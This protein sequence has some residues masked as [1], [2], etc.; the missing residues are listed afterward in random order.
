MAYFHKE[1]DSYLQGQ[2][3]FPNGQ[4]SFQKEEF[5]SGQEEFSSRQREV[6][7]RR[8]RRD[9]LRGEYGALARLGFPVALTQ[10]GIIALAFADTIMVGHY[11]VAQLAAAAFVNSVFLIPMVMLMGL[12]GG[13]T[14]LVGA[15]YGAGDTRGVGEVARGGV[16]VDIIVGAILTLLMTGLYFL[17]DR[18]GQEESLL[19]EIKDYYLILLFSLLP[20]TIFNAFQQVSNGITDTATPMWM[21]L[22][23]VVLNIIGN[24]MLIYGNWGC[25]ELGL[26][27]AGI[28]TVVSRCAGAVGM[29]TVFFLRRRYRPYAVGFRNASPGAPLLRKVWLTSYPVMIQSGV[30]C[31]LWSF[32]AVV[33]GW[34]GAV[35]LAAYQ[36][37]NTIGQL[38]FMIFMSIGVAVS[39]RVANNIGAGNYPGASLSARAGLHLNWLLATG[40]SILFLG[41]GRILIGFFTPDM[42]VISSALLLLPPLALYQ[43][44]DAT[45]L[46][47]CNAIRGTSEVKPLLWISLAS[48]ILVGIPALLLFACQ[49][50]WGNLGVYY[51]FCVALLTAALLA[52]RVFARI[53]ARF[54]LN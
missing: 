50:G 34:F 33:C 54:I 27:G 45:Q 49:F 44:L 28:A 35:S 11:G 14:P 8:G 31:S 1:K 19:P 48:Y 21:I 15:L 30:E 24:Y 41:A 25:P 32:G 13:I 6:S 53:R 43:Y 29:V 22:G 39:V 4:S 37:V 26:R 3:S 2:S 17:L 46:T 18:F 42:E 52:W 16:R 7:S 51:S 40:A 36:I 23:S 12:S 9:E 5:S 10:V 20:M 47:Y 38:G